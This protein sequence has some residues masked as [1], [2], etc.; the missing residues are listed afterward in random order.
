MRL[1]IV[2]VLVAMFLAA[3]DQTI[4]ATALATIGRDLGNFELLPWVVTAYL[5]TSTAVT[6]L[7]GKISDIHGRR[8]TLLVGICVF[9]LGSV[10][11][12]LAPNMLTLILARGVQGLG[13]GGLIS[14]AQTIIGDVV[15]PRERGR[16][17]VYIASVFISS[18]LAGPVLG[19]FFAEH[20][21]WSLIFWIN[22]PLG[23][24]AFVMTDRLL[25]KLPR[26]ERPHAIDYPGA[27]LLVAAT[28]VLMLALNWGGTRYP[29][30][31]APIG[32]LVVGSIVL[33]LLFAFRLGRAAEPL[34]PL[35][36]FRSAVVRNGTL[37]ACFG[38][39][40]FIGMSIYVPV[41]L[42]TV[43]GFSAAGSG[44]ALVGTVVGATFSGRL[45]SHVT[46]YRRLPVAGLCLALLATFALTLAP[47]G[48]PLVALEILFT[49]FSIGLGSLLPVTTVAIQNAVSPHQLGTATAGMNFFRSLGGAFVVAIFGALLLGGGAGMAMREAVS[50]NGTADE[51]AT[52]FRLVFATATAFLAISLLFLLR[53]EE[54][55]LKGGSQQEGHT[56]TAAG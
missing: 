27:V 37:S 40:V 44:L 43:R 29:W 10:A 19:G 38:M 30:I 53:M 21:H 1:I 18:S 24:L 36:L 51:I 23:I 56:A 33:W 13:G 41:Y 25:R 34:I 52:A 12:A 20:L 55:P 11:C 9:V 14:L 32:G 4:V 49:M 5:V 2:G 31:S 7:Y 47:G 26:H 39:G 28:S 45:M 3:L 22:V 8:P 48:I 54:L 50:I 42:E 16:Y 35:A 46:H 17:Q 15:S 6:P